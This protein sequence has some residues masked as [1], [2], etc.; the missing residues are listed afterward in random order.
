MNE[1]YAACLAARNDRAGDA[2]AGFNDMQVQPMSVR[3]ES[4]SDPHQALPGYAVEGS[5][6]GSAFS[7]GRIAE[8]GDRRQRPPG[9]LSRESSRLIQRQISV[10]RRPGRGRRR[11]RSGTT[12]REPIR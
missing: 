11:C 5:T 1:M 8:L 12:S 3:I 9:R 7:D 2:I 6:A 4:P 10:R